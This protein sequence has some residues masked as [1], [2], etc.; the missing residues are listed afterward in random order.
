[1]NMTT[2]TSK[3][4]K[5]WRGARAFRTPQRRLP[6]FLPLSFQRQGVATLTDASRERRDDVK[7]GMVVVGGTKGIG[8]ALVRQALQRTKGPVVVVGRSASHTHPELSTLIEQHG[9]RV[10]L[11]EMD[12]TDEESVKSGVENVVTQLSPSRVEVVLNTV[13]ILH[14]KDTMPERSLSAVSSDWM[15]KNFSINSVGHI[16][17]AKHFAEL[18][19]QSK[20]ETKRPSVIASLSA[21]VG[22]VSDN[23][24]GGW[25]SYRASKAAQN[26]L[27]KCASIELKRKGIVVLSLHPG[28]VATDL[29]LPFQKN[30]AKDKLFTSDYSAECLFN[31]VEGAELTDTGKF[32]AWDG[33]EIPY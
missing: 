22:S 23:G 29:S 13:G 33:K 2:M 21:R 7:A 16:L 6:Y 30:V 17:V 31:I 26:Q 32:I 19:S 3:H 4:T 15:L 8:L 9:H 20:R 1:M 11:V 25:Y 10:K 27:M 14:S 12:I 5:L 24:L 18:L 28:T